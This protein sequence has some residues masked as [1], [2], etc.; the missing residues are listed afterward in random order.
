MQY[1]ML[2][3]SIYAAVESQVGFSCE[4]ATDFILA[5]GI[6][7]IELGFETVGV[8]ESLGSV[9]KIGLESIIVKITEWTLMVARQETES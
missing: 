3:Q 5:V 2:L 8:V 9:G 1:F 4:T 7:K 6:Q